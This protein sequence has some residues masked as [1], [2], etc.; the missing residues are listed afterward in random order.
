MTAK[1]T[2][3]KG[4]KITGMAFHVSMPLTPLLNCAPPARGRQFI[5]GKWLHTQSRPDES[6]AI[7]FT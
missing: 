4:K 6:A 1:T 7:K 5:H 3:G 2:P